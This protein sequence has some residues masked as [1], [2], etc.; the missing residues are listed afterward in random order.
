VAT[1]LAAA[2]MEEIVAKPFADPDLPL[3]FGLGPEAGEASRTGFDNI[4]DYHGLA[5]SVGALRG[6]D[7]VSLADGS[8]SKFSRSATVMY[9]NLPGR[10]AALGPGF[11]VVTVEVKYDGASP[12]TLT[13]LISS[14]ERR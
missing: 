1:D 2:L 8:L 5:E 6:P 13:R 12:V 4:D 11:V 7:G 10:N 3:T 14:E 9:V